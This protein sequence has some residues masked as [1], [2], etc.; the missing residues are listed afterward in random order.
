[1][2]DGRGKKIIEMTPDEILKRFPPKHRGTGCMGRGTEWRIEN[3]KRKPGFCPCVIKQ[4]RASK[5]T[6]KLVL[7]KS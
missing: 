2:K 1:M 4:V 5:F 6:V 3:G 7:E